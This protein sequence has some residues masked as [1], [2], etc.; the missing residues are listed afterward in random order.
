MHIKDPHFEAM[1]KLTEAFKELEKY[2][3]EGDYVEMDKD[4]LL[5]L[6]RTSAANLDKAIRSAYE[7]GFIM[8]L[9]R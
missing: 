5:Y 7:Y 2:E 1:I 6:R 8:G 4:V 9:K 3:K